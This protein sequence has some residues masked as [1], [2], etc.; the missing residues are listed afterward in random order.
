MQKVSL[1]RPIGQPF[2]EQEIFLNDIKKPSGLCCFRKRK[3]DEQPSRSIDDSLLTERLKDLQ[4]R[5][6]ALVEPGISVDDIEKSVGPSNKIE[7]A[8]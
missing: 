4:N 2:D 3:S 6:K 7:N 8:V 5:E 1:T